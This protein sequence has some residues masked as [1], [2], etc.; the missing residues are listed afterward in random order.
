MRPL[1][2]QTSG[3]R[4]TPWSAAA[5]APPRC[6]A[7]KGT[8]DTDVLGLAAHVYPLLLSM[9]HAHQLRHAVSPIQ[10]AVTHLNI[11]ELFVPLLQH[12]Q[13]LRHIVLQL[14]SACALHRSSSSL[15]FWENPSRATEAARAHQL[16]PAS[17]L[18]FAVRQAVPA[19]GRAA[20]PGVVEQGGRRGRPGRDR[21]G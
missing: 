15:L 7:R 9:H 4:R 20:H 14:H 19:G 13:Q 21:D 16:R 11:A 6:N 2:P 12:Q 1:R 3:Q 18:T 8:C 10:Q 17:G 5:P